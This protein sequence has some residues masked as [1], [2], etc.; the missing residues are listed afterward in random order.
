[1]ARKHIPKQFDVD[2]EEEVRFAVAKYFLELDFVESQISFEDQF[3]VRLGHTECEVNGKRQDGLLRGRSDILIT[4]NGTNLAVIETKRPDHGLTD[5][6]AEQAI[7]YARLLRQIAPFAIVTNGT[8][9]KVYDVFSAELQ[10]LETPVDSAW[11]KNGRQSSPI[12]EHLRFD[13]AR[14]LFRFN[15][16]AIVAFCKAQLETGL[17]H[18]RGTVADWRFYVPELFVPRKNIVTHF[19][20]WIDSDLPVFAI[21]G[22]SGTGKTNSMCSLAE[23]ASKNHLVLFYQAIQLNKGLVTAIQEDFIWE[24]HAD[25]HIS[26]FVQRLS[27]FAE[28]QDCSL[29]I[30]V[31]GLD[32]F[33]C[34]KTSLQIELSDLVQ[35]TSDLPVKICVSCK[36]FDWDTFV[37]DRGQTFNEFAKRIFQLRDSVHRPEIISPPK[38]ED[39]GVQIGEFSQE[40]RDKAFQKYKIAY[41]LSGDLIGD[42]AKECVFPLMLRFVAEAYQDGELNLSSTFSNIEI[43]NTYW[44]RRI[45]RLNSELQDTAKTMLSQIATLSVETGDRYIDLAA[46][47]KAMTEQHIHWNGHANNVLNELLRQNFLRRVAQDSQ[48][49]FTFAFER[50]RAYVYSVVA[51]NWDSPNTEAALGDI[52]NIARNRLGLETIEFYF[53]HIDRGQTEL[54]T[55]IALSDFDLFT[56]LTSSLAFKSSIMDIGP[57]IRADA[58]KRRLERFAIAH[59]KIKH[60]HFPELRTRLLPYS[61]ADTGVWVSSNGDMLQLRRCTGEMPEQVAIVEDN[62]ASKLINGES[63]SEEFLQTLGGEGTIYLGTN[64]LFETLPQKYAWDIVF[65]NLKDL[66]DGRLLNESMTPIILQERIWDILLDHSHKDDTDSWHNYLELLEY[67]SLQ[68]ISRTRIA[69]LLEKVNHYYSKTFVKKTNEQESSKAADSLLEKHKMEIFRLNYWLELLVE[70]GSSLELPKSSRRDMYNILKDVNKTS[71][72]EQMVTKLV[73]HIFAEYKLLLQTNFPN[74]LERFSLY[75]IKD[76]TNILIEVWKSPSPYSSD[77]MYVTYAILPNVTELPANMIVVVNHGNSMSGFVP[78]KYENSETVGLGGD[79]GEAELD[80]NINGI[81]IREPKAILYKTKLDISIPITSQVYQLIAVEMIRRFGSFRDRLSRKSL[82]T[83]T[84][85][86]VIAREYV[87]AHDNRNPG[88]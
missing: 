37:I 74:F 42:M 38:A 14:R 60:T 88:T 48:D 29:L 21:V 2:S 33:A 10:E 57:E 31:D 6:D 43:F 44:R 12:G 58:Y 86:R 8:D 70:L 81:Q 62:L 24:S 64:K 55:E 3:K 15:P 52:Q 76:D 72:A 7:S 51:R 56:H 35:K 71:E 46:L 87:A 5:A 13:A 1:M 53:T 49:R 63:V 84:L 16:D 20:Q 61:D 26:F 4:Y 66:V 40:E 68:E 28:S 22:D 50:I 9:T 32:E 59:S 69:H 18:L 19:E 34:E 41:N 30:F 23:Q 27:D 73:E 25:K 75:N 85:N 45:G 82:G 54:L 80:L 11:E 47:R 78:L 39:V 83:E 67:S 77:F 79:Y 36:S 17:S 65:S